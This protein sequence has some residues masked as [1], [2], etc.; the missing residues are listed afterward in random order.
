M[1]F[2]GAQN[3]VVAAFQRCLTVRL[4]VLETAKSVIP[5]DDGFW[6]RHMKTAVY[7]RNYFLLLSLFRETI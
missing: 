6:S 3:L 4:G 2:D 5:Y 1:G 7:T